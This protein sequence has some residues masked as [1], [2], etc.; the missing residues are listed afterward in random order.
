MSSTA[1]DLQRVYV[2]LDC[3]TCYV[4]FTKICRL[5]GLYV[6][7]AAEGK[8]HVTFPVLTLT[9]SFLPVLFLF[10]CIITVSQ[11]V[12]VIWQRKWTAITWL[13]AVM[14][15][16]TIMD[17]MDL[18]TPVWNLMVSCTQLTRHV[19]YLTFE[20]SYHRGTPFR[21]MNHC[22]ESLI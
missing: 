9:T 21:L 20:L 6:N 11:E 22:I 12:G 1:T 3:V 5:I 19:L 2:S 17:Q 18:L 15:Y 10:E 7:R 13:Y 8:C 16:S 14:R 4:R